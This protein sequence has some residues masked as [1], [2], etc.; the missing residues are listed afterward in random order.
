MFESFIN[1]DVRE[2][3]SYIL[4]SESSIIIFYIML[5]CKHLNL[6]FLLFVYTEEI[7]YIA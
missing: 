2:Y 5:Y 6:S 1:I 4:D 3:S 7:Y